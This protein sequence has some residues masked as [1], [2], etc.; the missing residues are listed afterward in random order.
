MPTC[1][2]SCAYPEFPRATRV[3]LDRAGFDDV[4]VYAPNL[5]A[6]FPGASVRANQRVWECLLSADLLRRAAFEVRPAEREPGA[7][8]RVL[9]EGL[10]CAEAAL[11]RGRDLRPAVESTLR[12]MARIPVDDRPRPRVLLVGNLF[13]RFNPKLN[14]S[15]VERIE[16]LGAQVASPPMSDYTLTARLQNRRLLQQENLPRRWRVQNHLF[17]RALEDG[18]ERYESMARRAGAPGRR[19]PF[20]DLERYVTERLGIPWSLGG[21]TLSV[22]GRVLQTIDTDRPDAVVHINS[23][24]CQPAYVTDALLEGILVEAEIPFLNLYY[25][26]HEDHA[27]AVTSL[28]QFLGEASTRSRRGSPQRRGGR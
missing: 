23:L 27:S 19:L 7:A 4:P 11:R 21:E 24:F 16:A 26:G 15:I 6:F 12:E 1:S 3:A 2:Y 28:V 22:L 10:A 25:D 20:G 18:L 8:N 9:E 13:L 17:V 5:F 14:R